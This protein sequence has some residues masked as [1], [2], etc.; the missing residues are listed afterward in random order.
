MAHDDGPGVQISTG[1]AVGIGV[2]ILFAIAM[3]VFLVL[4]TFYW[5]RKALGKPAPTEEPQPQPPPQQEEAELDGTGPTTTKPH[6]VDSSPRS[7]SSGELKPWQQYQE[8][9]APYSIPMYELGTETEIPAPPAEMDAPGVIH[10]APSS[11][12][13]AT[14][15]FYN[16]SSS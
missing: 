16:A 11:S 6:E 9:A 1:T 10:E 12:L 15:S 13:P 4:V 14:R 3:I 7:R 2:G 8:L 5:R